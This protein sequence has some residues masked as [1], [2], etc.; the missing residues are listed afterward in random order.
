MASYNHVLLIGNLTRDVDAKSLPS[1]TAICDIGLAI[2]ERAKRGD[3]WV[4]SV[5]FVDVTLFGRNA[6]VAAEYCSKG[7]S[8]L[9]GGH[10][11]LDQWEQDGQKRS[12]LKVV[13]DKLQ[14]LGASGKPQGRPQDAGKASGP[15]KGRKRQETRPET[16]EGTPVGDDEIPF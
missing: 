3:A 13:G 6:E 2:N 9:I 10:L 16:P 5:T 12:K 7:S 11:K 14:M 1:G 15:P 8:V 4:D